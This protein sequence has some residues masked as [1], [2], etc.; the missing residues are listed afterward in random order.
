MQDVEFTKIKWLTQQAA[1]LKGNTWTK[2]QSTGN[3][4]RFIPCKQHIPIIRLHKEI[5]IS[6][7]EIFKP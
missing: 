4:E 2:C 6:D 1:D 7:T 5:S 3:L